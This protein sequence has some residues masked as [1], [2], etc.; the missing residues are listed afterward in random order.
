MSLEKADADSEHINILDTNLE[1]D[2]ILEML[3][4]LRLKIFHIETTTGPSRRTT[5]IQNEIKRLE[6]QLAYCVDQA[7]GLTEKV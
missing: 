1:E 5:N 7:K 2:Q 6:S 4:E 3:S